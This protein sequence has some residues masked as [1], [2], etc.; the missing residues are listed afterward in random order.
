MSEAQSFYDLCPL[1]KKGEPFPFS[2][3]KGK[4]VIIVN[5]ASKCG[6]TPQYKQLQELSEKYHDKG[7]EIIG[8]PCNQFGRQEP[9]NAEEIAS[10]C[11]LNYGVSF[12]V[13]KK[14]DV[15]GSN[16]DPVYVWLKSKKSG[17]LGFRGIKW[18]F[19]KF[20]I[21]REGN[22]VERYGSITNPTSLEP[23]IEKLL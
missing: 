11:S 19:E 8:F 7:V 16:A 6:F 3:L 18:N 23:S 14:V 5:V 1:D 9:G 13:L 15:N 4:V 20:L 10:F 17:L 21:D 22:V 12:P 2:Q